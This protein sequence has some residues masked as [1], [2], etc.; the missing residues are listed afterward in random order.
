MREQ[1]QQQQQL[2]TLSLTC[3][4]AADSAILSGAEADGR[5]V[6]GM[7]SGNREVCVVER[8]CSEAKVTLKLSCAQLM[9]QAAAALHWL[10]AK[11]SSRSP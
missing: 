6:P 5:I 2:R 10:S 7:G 4:Q 3:T 8:Q 11:S 9:D 1:Q